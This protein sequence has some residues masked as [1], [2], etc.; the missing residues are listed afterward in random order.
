M[1]AEFRSVTGRAH[2]FTALKA[3]SAM[4]SLGKRISLVQFRVRAPSFVAVRKDRSRASAQ[5]GFISPPCPGQHWRL[6]P[7]PPPR[8]SLPISLVT[9]SCRGSTGWRI[10]FLFARVAQR[11]GTTSRASPVQVRFLPRAPNR[12]RNA[13]WPR[14][15][16]QNAESRSD[17]F[18]FLVNFRGQ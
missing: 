16:A 8:S 2:H 12:T 11:R 1:S 18:A 7:F 10:H 14:E 3:L 9:K 4:H 6:R 15:N 5:V 13:E 17:F